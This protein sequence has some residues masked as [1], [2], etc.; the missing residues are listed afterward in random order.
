MWHQ[1]HYVALA[2]ADTR[3]VRERAVRIRGCIFA[4]LGRRV[5]EHN[6]VVALK[7]DEGRLVARIISLGMRN[8]HFQ[9]PPGFGL[10]SE[11]RVRSFDAN[12][13]LPAD[14]AQTGVAREHT[15]QQAR[16]AK[17]LKAVADAEDKSAGARE[18]LNRAHHGRKPR[19][20]AR[21]QVIAISKAARQNDGVKTHDLC[22]L[23]PEEF[24]LLMKD[25]AQGVVGIVVAVRARK[26]DHTEFHRASS[27]LIRAFYHSRE[28]DSPLYC[29]PGG[30]NQKSVTT[31][32]IYLTCETFS[33]AAR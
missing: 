29:D 11:R 23:M 22:G 3:D 18:F 19:N 2:V 25:L 13:Y 31:A 1:S 32:R 8:R 9:H 20:R 21:A 10:D 16:L 26:H 33:A 15:R 4:P 28:A 17:N 7:L 5:T 12:V 30:S 24:N 14:K 6:L 27:P